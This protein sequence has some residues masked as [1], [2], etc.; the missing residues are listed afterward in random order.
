MAREL[1]I[2]AVLPAAYIGDA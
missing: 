1:G 2:K